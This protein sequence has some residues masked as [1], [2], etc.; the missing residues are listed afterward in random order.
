RAARPRTSRLGRGGAGKT[1]SVIARI[2]TAYVRRRRLGIPSRRAARQVP[3]EV[4]DELVEDEP[5][6][7]HVP[8]VLV[9]DHPDLEPE[10]ELGE[11]AP[12][13]GRAARE[14]ELA[15]ADADAG[16][17]RGELRQIAVAPEDEV[18]RRGLEPCGRARLD[19]AA[20]AVAPD[21]RVRAEL[22]RRARGAAGGE[23]AL[24][25]EEPELDL[26]H[27]PRDERLLRRSH[28]AHGDVRVAAQE[29]L[30]PVRER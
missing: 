24:R 3:L 2:R 23:V 21:E 26:P 16:T 5:D 8:E 20:P 10:G 1:K 11:H 22:G 4:L 7:A 18:A 12:E 9:R 17:E 6:A 29:V 13:T 25:R 27:A 30:V 15:G 14:G 19:D 28:H